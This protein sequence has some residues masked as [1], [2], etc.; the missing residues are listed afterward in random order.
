MEK[1]RNKMNSK[2]LDEVL[3]AWNML[4][5]VKPTEVPKRGTEIKSSLLKDGKKRMETE[6]AL[7][8]GYIWEGTEL[9][10][11][12]TYGVQSH[13]YLNCFEQI[14]LIQFMRGHFNNDEEIIEEDSTLL[15]GLFFSV[16]DKGG[17]IADSL[18]VPFVMYLAKQLN[19][20]SKVSYDSMMADYKSAMRLFKE[21]GEAVFLNGIT[22][23]ALHDIKQIYSRNFGGIEPVERF[24]IETEVKKINNLSSKKNFNSFYLEDL[25][26]ILQKGGNR[27]IHQFIEA[28]DKKTNI[29][30]NREYIEHVLQPKFLPVGRWLSPVEHR[31]SLMQQVAVNQA[32]NS[33]QTIDS[34]NGPPGTGKTTLLKEIFANVVVNRAMEMVKFQDPKKAFTFD[35]EINLGQF[36][37][38]ISILNKKLTRF[39]MVV[40]SSNNGAVENISKELPQKKE[41]A[42]SEADQQDSKF[43]E[44]EKAYAEKAEELSFFRETAG[45]LLGKDEE[46]WGLFAAV[47]G[48]K[49][50][51]NEFSS[52]LM[53]KR[54][55]PNR[56]IDQLSQLAAKS[57]Q[58]NW[59]QVVQEFNDLHASIE[60]K[61]SKLQELADEFSQFEQKQARLRELHVQLEANDQTETEVREKMTRLANKRELTERKLQ[62][63][64]ELTFFQRLLGKK[65]VEKEAIQ[66]KLTECLEELDAFGD[67]QFEVQQ[68][69]KGL[70]EE[71]QQLEV[72]RQSFDEKISNYKTQGLVL[73]TAAYWEENP[74]AYENRQQQTIWLTDEL[75]FER[76]M[77]FLKAMEVHKLFL[78]LNSETI[79]V[80]VRLLMNR[81]KLNLND[82]DHIRY[83][84]NMWNIIHLITPVVSTTFASFSSLYNGIDDNFIQYLFIDEAGQASPQEAAGALWRSRKAIIVGD[85]IQIEPVVT[86]DKTILTDIRKHYQLEEDFIGLNASVQSLADRAN[87]FGTWKLGNEWIGTPLWVHRRCLD[88]MFSIANEIAYEGKMVLAHKKMGKVAWYDCKGKAVSGQYV[89]EQGELIAELIAKHWQTDGK[90]PNVFV[91]TPFTKVKEGLKAAV[92][93]KLK[94]MEIEEDKINTWTKKSIGTVHTFQG[95]EA[96]IVYFVAGTDADSEGAAQW[97]CAKPNLLNVAVTR[98]KKEFYII[99]D[100]Q[101]FSTKPYYETFAN[102]IK[103][104]QVDF[105]EKE[106]NLSLR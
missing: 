101:R 20:R 18:F 94:S 47:L 7:I 41:A 95:K 17:Y 96:S 21:Q 100:Y 16:D 42:R 68:R 99:A 89:S 72:E 86:I 81:D 88:P 54:D 82:A 90:E 14:K 13:Y 76:G 56:L 19:N 29:N 51:I 57:S 69:Q 28:A 103:V 50:N 91:I 67:Q 102:Y 37:Y 63:S 70:R 53:G 44:Y 73:P 39:S 6:S 83:L 36:K 23:Q 84:K 78:V 65:N 93:A 5:A 22:E 105:S 58:K 55:E 38:Q 43:P 34:V 8:N 97:S 35:K 49:N 25:Q 31:L 1:R 15:F 52:I 59:Q 74:A 40:A 98:A 104:E 48:K 64:P 45:K 3:K 4:E 77:L 12:E 33:G 71:Q 46:A 87:A 10:D 92:E 79:K 61:K 60:Q 32:L 11:D 30:E 26:S 9:K 66:K 75:N 27:T 24:Y 62:L 106:Q 2:K 80:T 85:P